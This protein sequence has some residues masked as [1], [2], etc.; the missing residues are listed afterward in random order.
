MN[1]EMANVSEAFDDQY[2][3]SI[4]SVVSSTKRY[5]VDANQLAKLWNIGLSTA[6]KTIKCT[7]Q[8]GVRNTMYP[9]ER[10]FRTKQAQLRYK[11][12]SGR[13]GTFYTDTFFANTNSLNGCKMAQIYVNDLSFT[14]VYP[15]KNKSD[16]P[17]TLSN[18]I[19]DVGIPHTIHSD[20]APEIEKGKFRQLFKDYGIIQT[21]T[22]PYSPW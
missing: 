4:A 6:M 19:H 5:N 14:K 8:K 9:I 17:D 10:R 13:H 15:M 2:I 1:T 21:F 22:E 12:L 18:F 20:N 7:T 16:I 3:L 11:Q